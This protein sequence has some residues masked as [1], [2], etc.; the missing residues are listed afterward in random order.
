[1]PTLETPRLILRAHVPSD[2]DALTTCWSDP[3]VFRFIGGRSFTR[4]ESWA[5]LLR[6]VGQWSVFGWG[7]F[8]VLE[9]E[10][11]RYVGDVG[12]GNFERGIAAFEGAPEAGWVLASWAHGRGFA[13]EALAAATA[14]LDAN[15][16][17]PRTVCM[18]DNDNAGSHRVAA[19]AGYR[20][21]S[22]TTY[23]DSPVV[24]Y[25]RRR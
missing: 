1:M 20:E 4:E 13:S 18:I 3:A 25:E 6:Y 22:R 11:N 7:M 5:R 10:T 19:K 21:L 12:F 8:A 23:K 15:I 17:P 2:L 24:L 9:R 16:D 14:W